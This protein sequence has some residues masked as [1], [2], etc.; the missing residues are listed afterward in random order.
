MVGAREQRRWNFVR[1]Y[2]FLCGYSSQIGIDDVDTVGIASGFPYAGN[3]IYFMMPKH[4]ICSKI[5][6]QSMLKRNFSVQHVQETLFLLLKDICF[7]GIIMYFKPKSS[8]FL[9][10]V[11][12]TKLVLI[13][14]IVHAILKLLFLFGIILD[15]LNF[16]CHVLFVNFL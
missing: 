7:L 8:L 10:Y 3:E 4:L 16:S 15:I 13:W 1:P 14:I 9:D 5:Y 12:S 6:D 2:F 11:E